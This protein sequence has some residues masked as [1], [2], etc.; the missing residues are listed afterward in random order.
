MVT[1]Q[2]RVNIRGIAPGGKEEHE[3]GWLGWS[4]LRALSRDGT[5][6]LFEEEAE[7]GGPNYTVFLRNTDGSPPV[8]IGEGVAGAISPDNKWVITMPTKFGALSVVPTGAGESRQLT[9]DRINYTAVEYLPD[10]KQLLAAGIEPG[11]GARDYLIDVSTGDAKPLTPEGVVGRVLSPDGREIEVTGPDGTPG[12]WSLDGNM[13]KPIAGLD[14]SKYTVVAWTPDQSSLY[15]TPRGSPGVTAKIYRFNLASGKMEFWKEFGANLPAG[16][17][18][19][20]APLLP[21]QGDGY[22]YVYSQI[23]AEAY[24]VRGSK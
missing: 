3:L 1:H 5:E 22:A 14:S 17:S 7:G 11:H 8:R 19:V 21:V 10:G 12:I 18:H 6:V 24:V 4:V 15:V 13:M 20:D 16:A 2:Q 23:S 9:H